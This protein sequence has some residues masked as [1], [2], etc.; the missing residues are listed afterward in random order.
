MRT[1]LLIIALGLAVTS[2][3]AQTYVNFIR[4]QQQRTNV[5]WDMPVAQQGTGP[6]ALLAEEGGALFQLWTIAQQNS[7]D[8][9]LDQKLVGAYLPKGTVKIRTVDSYNGIPRIRVDQPFT[10]DFEIS[11]LLS[12]ANIPVSASSVLV[13]HHLAPNPGGTA[14]ITPAQAISGT[15]YSSAYISKNGLTSVPY[16]G[17]SIKAADPTKARGEEYFVLHALGEGQFSQTQIASA[18]LQV[19]PLASGS[20]SG[21]T[22]GQV[23]RGNPPALTVRLDDLYPRSDTYIRIYSNGKELGTVGAVIPGSMLVLDQE[24]PA[25][26]LL[27]VKDYGNLFDSEGAY[28]IELLTK[29]PFGI[30]RLQ[31]VNFQV[32]RTIHINAMIVEGGPAAP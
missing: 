31:S 1:P 7:K 16:T 11:N 12:G 17:S 25:S 5:V 28:R 4:Q 9:L 26:R 22:E 8:Y 6:A 13:E 20:M 32:D 24:F 15:P 30:D 19:W 10:V 2:A 27:T 21:I 23:V 14:V 3:Q 18:F 29:T